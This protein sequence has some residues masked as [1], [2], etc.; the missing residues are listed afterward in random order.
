VVGEVNFNGDHP[1]LAPKDSRI[2]PDPLIVCSAED[3][4]ASMDMYE[5]EED[6]D[7]LVIEFAPDALH[8]A[9]ISGGSP[10]AIEVP[11]AVADAM[12]EDEPHNVTFV[13]YLRIAISWGGFPGWECEVH[14][15]R[16][17][18]RLRV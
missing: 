13:E 12:V 8:K 17:L 10:Y 14:P 4:I 15:P 9:N 7:R 6:D 16:E 3:A 5:R 18:E 1:G 2:T 11:Q